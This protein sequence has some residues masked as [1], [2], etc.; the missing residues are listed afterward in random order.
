ML[1]TDYGEYR[2]AQ[3]EVLLR[4][5]LNQVGLT[6]GVDYIWK[7]NSMNVFTSIVNFATAERMTLAKMLLAK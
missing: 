5:T 1:V 4:N 3:F 7:P 2:P 6:M